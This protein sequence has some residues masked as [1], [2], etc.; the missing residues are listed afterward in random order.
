MLFCQQCNIA[1][2]LTLANPIS[3]CFRRPWFMLNNSYYSY[4]FVEKN[5][6][7]SSFSVKKA[8]TFFLLFGEWLLEGRWLCV[9]RYTWCM[10]QT[11]S[12]QNNRHYFNRFRRLL[13]RFEFGDDFNQV[14][15]TQNEIKVPDKNV[16][17]LVLLSP[18]R[19]GSKSIRG[20]QIRS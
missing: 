3:K 6:T 8:P 10:Q 4:F 14:V 15:C 12:E 17:M 7:F 19:Q 16:Q 1:L 9:T 13:N 5:P 18:A 11:N 2:S 20:H